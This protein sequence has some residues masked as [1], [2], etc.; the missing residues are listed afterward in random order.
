MI[1]KL[2]LILVVLSI[3]GC[4]MVVRLED[5]KALLEQKQQGIENLHTQGK[6]KITTWHDDDHEVTCYAA[7]TGGSVTGL[8]CIPDQLIIGGCTAGKEGFPDSCPTYRK[9][10]GSFE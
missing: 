5:G 6:N 7:V 3:M 10:T 8:S 2:F 1:K 9:R 4:D